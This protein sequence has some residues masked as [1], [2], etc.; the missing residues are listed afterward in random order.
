[1]NFLWFILI[2]GVAGWLAGQ[3]M[4]GKGY[5]ILGDIVLGIVGGVVGGWLF[6]ILGIGGGGL[7]GSLVTALVGAVILIWIVRMIKK[8]S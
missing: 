7:I 5:G 8:A 6:G 2:G 4:S 1:M 3:I